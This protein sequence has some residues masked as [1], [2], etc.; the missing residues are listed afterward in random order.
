[1]GQKYLQN[2]LNKNKINKR[3]NHLSKCQYL[4]LNY[5]ANNRVKLNKKTL[6]KNSL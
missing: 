4:D 3:S 1:M 5:F 6:D 2:R